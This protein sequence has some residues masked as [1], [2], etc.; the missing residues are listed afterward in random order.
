MRSVPGRRMC[1][2][3]LFVAVTA[4][5]C[6][7][8]DKAANRKSNPSASAVAAS[9]SPAAASSSAPAGST[10]AVCADVAA[11]KATTAKLDD[12]K[13]SRAA[14]SELAQGSSQLAS[15]LI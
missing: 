6:G 10:S 5:G 13:V 11:L 2:L 3:V 12:T 14:L 7:G 8:G 1:A 4:T 15:D 9:P